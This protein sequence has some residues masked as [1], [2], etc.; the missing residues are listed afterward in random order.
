MVRVRVKRECEGLHEGHPGRGRRQEAV[1]CRLR[2]HGEGGGAWWGRMARVRG[3]GERVHR[4]GA[5][6]GCKARVHG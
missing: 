3:E 4:E 2:V 5:W 1:G 6:Q